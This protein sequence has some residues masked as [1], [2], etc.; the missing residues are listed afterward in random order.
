MQSSAGNNCTDS[1]ASA[2]AGGS[3][4][5][6]TLEACKWQE[7]YCAT[8]SSSCFK[9][10]LGIFGEVFDELVEAKPRSLGWVLIKLCQSHGHAVRAHHGKMASVIARLFSETD[11]PRTNFVKDKLFG[12]KDGAPILSHDHP[13]MKHL[14]TTQFA[15]VR[16]CIPL[17]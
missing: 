2:C 11:D 4:R 17:P 6:G 7:A 14:T 1:H 13:V 5:R 8:L 16:W 12:V 10:N 9:H 15:K 3:C